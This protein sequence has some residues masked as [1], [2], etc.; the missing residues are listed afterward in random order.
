MSVTGIE[1]IRATAPALQPWFTWIVALAV[2]QGWDVAVTS[3]FRSMAEQERLYNRWRAGLQLLHAAR[4]G[5]SQHNFG[6]AVDMVIAG[7][8]NGPRQKALGFAWRREGG[9]W[10]VADPVHFGI[11]WQKPRGC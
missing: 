9:S 2:A 8:F 7:D 1:K 5:C 11:F 6:Y 10:N 4:P 3:G